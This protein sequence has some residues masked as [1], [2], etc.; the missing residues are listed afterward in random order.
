MDAAELVAELERLYCQGKDIGQYI[1]LHHCECS[2]K[3]GMAL[4]LASMR[5]FRDLLSDT[6]PVKKLLR[7]IGLKL[8][9]TPPDVRPQLI[10]QAV[11]LND[12][13]E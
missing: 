2:R 6:G 10:R 7:D 11:G 5:G 1:Y 4:I 9:G 13:S 3:Y 12:L 8:V